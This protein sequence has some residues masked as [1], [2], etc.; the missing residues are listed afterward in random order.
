MEFLLNKTKQL[1]GSLI[2]NISPQDDNNKNIRIKPKYQWVI[3]LFMIV[4]ILFPSIVMAESQN[5][6]YGVHLISPNSEE[7][8]AAANLVNSS[9]GDWGYITILIEDR[10]REN[11]DKWQTFF[12]QLRKKHLIPIVRLATHPEGALWTRPTMD[13]ADKWAEFL[14]S[15]NWPVKQRYVVIY[16]EPNHGSE[17]GGSV[18]AESYARVLDQT[19]NSLKAKNQNFFVLN[20]GFDAS[21]PEQLPNYSNQVSFMQRMETAVPGIFDKLDGW[22]SHSYPNPEFI[23]SP[24]GVGRGTVRTWVWE[25]QLLKEMNVKKDLPVFITE[26]GWRHAEGLNY[27]KNYPT[28]ETIS[29]YYKKAFEQAWN[30]DRVKAVTIF[31]LDY[32]QSPFDHFSFKKLNKVAS[33][34][35]L[36]EHTPEDEDPNFYNHYTAVKKLEKQ[37]GQPLQLKK[38]QHIKGTIP[39]ILVSNEDYIFDIT[40]KNTGESIWNE[41]GQFNVKAVLGGEESGFKEISLSNET[42]IDPNQEFTFHIRLKPSIDGDIKLGLQFFEGEQAFDTEPRE[43]I[44]QV[45]PPVIVITKSGLEW[46][47]DY[48]GEYTLEISGNGQEITKTITLDKEGTSQEVEVRNLLPNYDYSFKLK[49]QHYH[50]K[51]IDLKVVSGINTLNFGNLQPDIPSTF[52]KPDKFWEILPFSN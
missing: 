19:I 18:D 13:D 44:F 20:A 1:I 16:N 29:K 41:Y 28:A 10:D 52:L 22:S 49:K 48:S 2:S 4:A 23:G 36:G 12:N 8:D 33:E 47:D 21:A 14:D 9:G 5:N 17:W 3:S 43:F 26:T 34:N 25:L 51:D 6:K 15:L 35:V 32:Q 11:K 31:L 30:D 38:A 50:T 46:K 45:K 37:K 40:F 7:V 42:K 24:D 39:Q 27:N